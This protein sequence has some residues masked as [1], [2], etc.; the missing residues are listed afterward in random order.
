MQLQFWGAAGAAVVVAL[1]SGVAEHRRR[2]RRDLERV[3]LMPWMAIQMAAL[4]AALVLASVA[5]NSQ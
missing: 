1:V 3:G 5:L 4:F 2:R